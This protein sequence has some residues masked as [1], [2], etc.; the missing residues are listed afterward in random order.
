[1]LLENKILIDQ[2]EDLSKILSQWNDEIIIGGGVALVLYDLILSKANSGAVGTT[3]IDYLIP[4]KPIKT[5]T[6]KISQILMD[7][8]YELRM[9]TLTQPAV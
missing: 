6:Q 5:S 7:H 8:G 9:K 3:D 4:R 2:I 1:M